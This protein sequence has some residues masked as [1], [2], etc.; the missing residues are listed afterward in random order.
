[1][2]SP[3]LQ[4]R[5]ELWTLRLA[6]WQKSRYKPSDADQFYQSYFSG[7]HIEAYQRDIRHVLRRREIADWIARDRVSGIVIDI[8]CGVGDILQ[9]FEKGFWRVGTDFSGAQLGYAHALLGDEARFAR[10]SAYGLPFRDSVADVV[11]CM[12]VIE[13]LENDA[14]AVREIHRVLKPGG[15]LVA[16]VPGQYYWPEYRDLMGHWRHY[17]R[18]AFQA[19]LSEAGLRVVRVL[20]SYPGL[21][22]SYLR[23]YIPLK[24][25]TVLANR[26][27]QEQTTVYSFGLP[28][29][30]QP[31]Y[32]LVEARFMRLAALESQKADDQEDRGTFVVAQKARP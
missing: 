4:D 29:S 19:L 8:G 16:S 7:E 30:K 31:L 1:M 21:N 15:Y 6:K 5:V 18:E 28:W 27:C 25:A 3:T 20:N 24:L 9:I 13:H 2:R 10:A 11:V 14:L 23:T 22:R 26:F 32:D 17:S 12:E